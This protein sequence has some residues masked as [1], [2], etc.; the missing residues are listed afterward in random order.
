M[1]NIFVIFTAALLLPLLAFGQLDS[2]QTQTLKATDANVKKTAVQN[3]FKASLGA[4]LAARQ[5]L[6]KGEYSDAFKKAA[7]ALTLAGQGEELAKEYNIKIVYGWVS[8]ASVQGGVEHPLVMF[9]DMNDVKIFG[10]VMSSGN[11]VLTDENTAKYEPE[12]RD[13]SFLLAYL[14]EG[15]A[16]PSDLIFID[17][18]FRNWEGCRKA[19]SQ[20]TNLKHPA[21]EYCVN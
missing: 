6:E 14:R 21:E 1:K 9:Q 17:E 16:M 2:V 10:A 15:A 20:L 5:F 7:Q 8:G 4:A 19:L 13:H 11:I 12:G 3:K 18:A